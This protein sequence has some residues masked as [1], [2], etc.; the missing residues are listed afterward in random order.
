MK[1]LIFPL[2][3][4]ILLMVSAV[5]AVATQSWN[6]AG[7]YSVKF[8]TPKADGI[9]KKLSGDILFDPNNLNASK[10]NVLVDVNSIN[11]GNGMK[12]T[13]AK[14][15]KFLDAAKYPNIAFTSSQITKSGN[16]YQVKGI[17]ELHGVRR[18]IAFPFTFQGNTFAGSFQVNCK[19]FGMNEMGGGNEDIVKISLSV[20][21]T[22]KAI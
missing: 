1:K 16:A 8:T 10:F 20:P 22:K 5:A 9:F 17:L 18:E 21:V 2:L 19:D 15:A 13:H 4:G 12:N 14:Q 6:I 7:G 11:T 3:A